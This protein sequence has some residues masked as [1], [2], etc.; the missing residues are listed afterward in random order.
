MKGENKGRFD[1]NIKFSNIKESIEF[2]LP[3]AKTLLRPINIMNRDEG[4]KL[5]L[6]IFV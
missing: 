2:L 5:P 4:S 1:Q 3:L 6:N